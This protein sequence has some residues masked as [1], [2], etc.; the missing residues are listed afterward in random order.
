ML[1]EGL[2]Q[3]ISNY[4]NVKNKAPQVAHNNKTAILYYQSFREIDNIFSYIEGK[5]CNPAFWKNAE[6]KLNLPKLK[7]MKI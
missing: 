1:I 5:P 6:R 3:T 4:C 7:N 2:N